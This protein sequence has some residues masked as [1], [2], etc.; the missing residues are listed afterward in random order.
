MFSKLSYL[1]YLHYFRGQN[2]I[3]I[4][5]SKNPF[6]FNVLLDLLAGSLDMIIIIPMSKTVCC[7]FCNAVIKLL[8]KKSSLLLHKSGLSFTGWEISDTVWLF[9][10]TKIE[11]SL[12]VC[13]EGD[14]DDIFWIY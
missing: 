3:D 9:T 10:V 13:V 2:E 1:I 4:A 12:C 5:K 8:Q 7:G 6:P 14:E 11:K